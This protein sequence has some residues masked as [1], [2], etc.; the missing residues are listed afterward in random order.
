LSARVPPCALVRSLACAEGP[1]V[2]EDY[3]SISLARMLAMGK[4]YRG[5][6]V[7]RNQKLRTEPGFGPCIFF[8]WYQRVD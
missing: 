2:S 7:I 8:I 6:W 5:I 1:C 3:L 4:G